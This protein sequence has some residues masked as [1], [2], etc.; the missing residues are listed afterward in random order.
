M[1][2]DYVAADMD[3]IIK[4]NHKCVGTLHFRYK[5]SLTGSSG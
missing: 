1:I 4:G 5:P 2:G 3:N